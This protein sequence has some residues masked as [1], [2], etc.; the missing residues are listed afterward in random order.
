M[1]K[2]V[3]FQP[4]L[5]K[6]MQYYEQTQKL[7][8]INTDRSNVNVNESGASV[9]NKSSRLNTNRSNVSYVG[10]SISRSSK[11]VYL[12]MMDWRS[13]KEQNL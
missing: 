5:Q 13:N 12:S 10:S 4:D 3:T 8:H 11:Q 7:N 9:N 1:L 6:T 2:G